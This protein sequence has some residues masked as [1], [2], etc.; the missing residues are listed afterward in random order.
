MAKGCIVHDAGDPC[1]ECAEIRRVALL[2][3]ALEAAEDLRSWTS[4]RVDPGKMSPRTSCCT[5]GACDFTRR[6]DA[7]MSAIA[8]GRETP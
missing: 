1:P 3:A 7:A 8:K 6:F 5:C 2:E 4:C